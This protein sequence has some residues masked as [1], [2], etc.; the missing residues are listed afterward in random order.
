[1]TPLST[2][3]TAQLSLSLARAAWWTAYATTPANLARNVRY[4]GGYG[5]DAG[6]KLTPDELIDDAMNTA[7]THLTRAQETLDALNEETARITQQA[8]ARKIAE[9]WRGRTIGI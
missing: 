9:D 4:G 8:E 2:I 1:M 6:D 3:L 7:N 5:E